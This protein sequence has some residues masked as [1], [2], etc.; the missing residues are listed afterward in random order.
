MLEHTV[1]RLNTESLH[2]LIPHEVAF[3][4]TPKA[5]FPLT[6]P[7]TGGRRLKLHVG[8]PQWWAEPGINQGEGGVPEEGQEGDGVR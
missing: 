2:V 1:A 8:M 3:S 5:N 6:K 4:H 7:K